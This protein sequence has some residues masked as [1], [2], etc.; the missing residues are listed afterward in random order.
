MDWT[1]LI[2]GSQLP[3]ASCQ[4]RAVQRLSAGRE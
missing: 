2:G 4:L 1:P 3:L